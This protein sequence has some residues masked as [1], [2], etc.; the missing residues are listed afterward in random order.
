MVPSRG[1]GWPE[2][3]AG[4]G[5]GIDPRAVPAPGVCGLRGWYRPGGGIGPG[6]RTIVQ[7]LA[8]RDFGDRKGEFDRAGGGGRAHPF[9]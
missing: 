7:S 9:P 6:R 8:H 3:G 1:C 4:S 2:G 5:G